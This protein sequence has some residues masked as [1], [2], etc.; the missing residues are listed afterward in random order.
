MQYHMGT[1]LQGTSWKGM[2]LQL[3]LCS[4][5]V[6]FSECPLS[7]VPIADG[8][9]WNLRIVDTI[10][11]QYLSFVERLSSFGGYFVQSVY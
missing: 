1:T 10:G 6:L 7:E 2:G 4:E 8:V 3:V 9:K 11:T 5:A